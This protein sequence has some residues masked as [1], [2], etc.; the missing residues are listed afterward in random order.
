MQHEEDAEEK[1]GDGNDEV[2]I[3][4]LPREGAAEERDDGIHSAAGPQRWHVSQLLPPVEIAQRDSRAPHPGAL[5]GHPGLPQQIG[6]RR[7]DAGDQ[8]Q[9]QQLHSQG[10]SSRETKALCGPVFRA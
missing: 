3:D 4:H 7:R 1:G 6:H 9:I 5:F 8:V 10:R 2:Q